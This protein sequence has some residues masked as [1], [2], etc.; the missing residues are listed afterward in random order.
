MTTQSSHVRDFTLLAG[1]VL[2]ASLV[3][4]A[5]LQVGTGGGTTAPGTWTSGGAV[6]NAFTAL[7]V[8]PAS[9]GTLF[10]SASGRVGGGTVSGDLYYAFTARSLDRA[11][12]TRLPTNSV[13]GSP[14]NPGTSFAGGQLIGASPSLSVSQA[15][16]NYAFGYNIGTNGT[17][18][19]TFFNNPRLDLAPARVA[20]F[21]VHVQYNASA[22]DSAVITMRLYDNLPAQRQPVASDVAVYTQTLN[23]A[24]SDF[25]FDSFQFISG[26]M[27]ANSTRWQFSNVAF[28]QNAGE[29]SDYILTHP[30]SALQSVVQVGPGGITAPGPWTSGAS[31]SNAILALTVV[32]ANFGNLYDSASGLVGGGTV[33]GDLYYAFTA[34]SLDRAGDTLLP[35]GSS[36]GQ[37]YNPGTSFAGGQ[38]IGTAPSLGLGQGYSNWALGYFKSVNGGSDGNR[39][40]FNPR[41]DMAPARVSLFDVRLHFNASSDDS[42]TV[43]MYTYD[44][45]PAGQLQPTATNTPSYTRQVTLNGNF[46]FNAFQFISGHADTTPSTRWRFSN[47]VFSR[48]ATT[49][50]DY[51][52]NPPVPARGTLV[53]IY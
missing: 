24:S 10:D 53:K 42:A 5:V 20:L 1:I 6:T 37:P 35:T 22:N 52:L 7:T 48:N 46:A 18:P 38:L 13:A 33:A 51:I 14:Y 3:Q 47:I 49:A 19:S 4:A 28:A 9:F 43:I 36:A 29:A 17:G 31:V 41:I 50:A 27:D 32:P 25:S 34:R 44:N 45:L 2:F 16:G 40:D 30:A 15:F 12:D 21:E 26:H 23:T 8:N 11:G 39:G